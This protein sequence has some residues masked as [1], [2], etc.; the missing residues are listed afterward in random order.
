MMS[1]KNKTPMPLQGIV[2]HDKRTKEILAEAHK[3]SPY[4][5]KKRLA[6]LT[7]SY[8]AAQIGTTNEGYAS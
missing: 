2:V 3:L 6:A 8:P 7:A 1:K 4:A 5:F